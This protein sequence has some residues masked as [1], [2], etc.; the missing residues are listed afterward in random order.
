MFKDGEGKFCWV[1]C[2]GWFVILILFLSTTWW[3]L[4]ERVINWLAI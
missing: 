1:E 2:I 3:A 4:G